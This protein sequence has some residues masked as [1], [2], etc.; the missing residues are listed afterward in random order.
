MNIRDRKIGIENL[1]KSLS[2]ELYANSV[3]IFLNLIVKIDFL[4]SFLSIF[5]A[6]DG[7][8]YLFSDVGIEY[9]KRGFF[10]FIY[11]VVR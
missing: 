5:S 11:W 1:I 2:S 7:N 6:D 9:L 4:C 10:Y 8:L 3:I